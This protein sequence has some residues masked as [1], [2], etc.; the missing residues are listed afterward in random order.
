[1]RNLPKKGFERQEGHHIYFHHV[2]GEKY[3]GVKTYVSH[4]AAVR[5]ISGGL[6]IAMKKQLKLDRTS[7]FVDLITCPMS[8]E[9]FNCILR[10]KNLL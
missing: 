4:S 3:T 7:D 2:V 8:G 10:D 1:M 9:Q 6:L 5:T